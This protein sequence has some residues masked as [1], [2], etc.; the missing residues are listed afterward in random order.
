MVCSFSGV[1]TANIHYRGRFSFS[2]TGIGRLTNL[3]NL[4]VCL[5]CFSDLTT[6]YQ[7]YFA[8]SNYTLSS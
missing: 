2:L 5:T 4:V 8:S 1:K 6:G 3:S 7:N